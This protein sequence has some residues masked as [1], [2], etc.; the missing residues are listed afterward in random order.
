MT[1]RSRSSRSLFTYRLFLSKMIL[2]PCAYLPSV[3]YFAELVRGGC[4]VDLGE[5]GRAH[6]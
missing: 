4:V 6:V 5:I 1:V 2:L 3:R